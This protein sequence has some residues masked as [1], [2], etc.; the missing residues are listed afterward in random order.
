MK[1]RDK[2]SI[3]LISARF[4]VIIRPGF[5]FMVSYFHT[6]FILR[7][8]RRNFK[9]LKMIIR[10]RYIYDVKFEFWFTLR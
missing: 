9:I 8:G 6:P 2:R 5:R 7:F 3:V 10:R 4:R 1:V